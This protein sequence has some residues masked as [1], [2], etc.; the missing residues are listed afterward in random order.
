MVGP[1]DPE[2]LEAI[3]EIVEYIESWR[4]LSFTGLGRLISDIFLAGGEYV[5]SSMYS[6]SVNSLQISTCPSLKDSFR[7]LKEGSLIVHFDMGM[8]LCGRKRKLL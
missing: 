2:L 3:V 1:D 4:L 7:P 6:S 5:N 8:Y